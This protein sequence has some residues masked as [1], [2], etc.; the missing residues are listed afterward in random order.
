MIKRFHMIF[1]QINFNQKMMEEE[2]E[3]DVIASTGKL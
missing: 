3:D 2:L 1:S